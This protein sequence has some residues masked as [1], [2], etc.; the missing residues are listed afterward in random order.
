MRIYSYSSYKRSPTGFAIG[1]I[2]SSELSGEAYIELKHCNDEFIEKLFKAGD[3]KN[4]YGKI[5]D[6]NEYIYMVKKL[7]CSFRND[8]N[9]A[10]KKYCNFAFVFD[11]V[12]D[13]IKF[14]NNFDSQLLTKLMNEFIVPDGSI[15]TF[16][17]KIQK[18]ALNK[19]VQCCMKETSSIQSVED[20]ITIEALSTNTDISAALSDL[21]SVN[22]SKEI[23]AVYSSKKKQGISAPII[24]A[25]IAVVVAIVIIAV[26]IASNH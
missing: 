2:E 4:V 5:P 8:D 15:E 3:V 6:S 24:I 23:G 19:F 14:K 26:I 10:A 25:S 22:V 17:L 13:Y 12:T 7:E 1:Y 16:G 18:A 9:E 20:H 21:L 11:N